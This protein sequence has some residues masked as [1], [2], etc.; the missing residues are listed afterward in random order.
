MSLENA[1]GA[2]IGLRDALRA[3]LENARGERHL[4]KRLD[5]HGLFER[6]EARGR[7]LASAA[8]LERELAAALARAAGALGL[9]EV[10]LARLEAAAPE[11]ARRL[12]E[13]LAEVRSLAGALRELDA[14]NASLARR[15]LRCVR[16]YVDALAPSPRFYE[17]LGAR[18]ASPSTADATVST[19]G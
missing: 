2:A 6:A 1:V 12:G 11:G 19:R 14:L 15:A 8:R 18:S 13:V 7:F 9:T 4:L 5:T 10:T 17:R 16:G 3:E